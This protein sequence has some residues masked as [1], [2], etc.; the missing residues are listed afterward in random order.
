MNL[1]PHLVGL[2]VALGFLTTLPIPQPPDNLF[3]DDPAIFGR[4]FGWYPI[5]GLLLGSLLALIG[6]LLAL[7]ALGVFARAGLLL[8]VWI[9]LTGG[10]HLDGVMD[11]CDALFAPVSPAR[12]LAILKDVYTGA[13]GVIGLVMVLGLKW[14]LLAQLLSKS[15]GLTALGVVMAAVWGR[16]IMVWVAQRYPY[17]RH[18]AECSDGQAS[19]VSLGGVMIQGLTDRQVVISSLAAIGIFSLGV[20]SHPLLLMTAVSPAT[21]L[22]VA[23]WAALRLDG[24]VTGDIYGALCE[25]T[26]LIAILSLSL[27]S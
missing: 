12:R 23:R 17:A 25:V 1:Y 8:L 15:M 20:L 3:A 27:V 22:L 9:L 2:R 24:G 13:F 5:I 16:W 6:W 4:S 10:L 11:A 7:T 21:G 26:E 18:T 14:V 19:V